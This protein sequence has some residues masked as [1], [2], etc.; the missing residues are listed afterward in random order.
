MV[1]PENATRLQRLQGFGGSHSSG[2]YFA[3]R[4]SQSFSSASSA[5][6]N[7]ESRSSVARSVIAAFDSNDC[8]GAGFVLR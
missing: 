7:G 1:S 6:E 5:V 8:D 3:L 2:S 4:S